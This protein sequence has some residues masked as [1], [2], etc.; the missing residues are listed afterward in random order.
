MIPSRL[1]KQ[2]VVPTIPLPVAAA[3]VPEP[4]FSPTLAFADFKCEYVW[5]RDH[6]IPPHSH[7]GP[8]FVYRVRASPGREISH[9][10]LPGQHNRGHIRTHRKSPTSLRPLRR[11]IGRRFRSLP[12]KATV[13][14][15]QVRRADMLRRDEQRKS[16]IAAVVAWNARFCPSAIEFARLS[17]DKIH[18]QQA[19]N[20]YYYAHLKVLD[21]TGP[22]HVFHARESRIREVRLE[23]RELINPVPTREAVQRARLE[24]SRL[25]NG[26]AARGAW[27][28]STREAGP[29][30][31]T[32]A[33]VVYD[34][35]QMWAS[36]PVA[37]DP[38]PAPLPPIEPV[39]EP[40]PAPASPVR[41]FS[42]LHAVWDDSSDDA[43][44]VDEEERL[45]IEEEEER[46]EVLDE[47]DDTES[48]M[49]ADSVSTTVSA[50]PVYD[51]AVPR[52]IP[53]PRRLGAPPVRQ[54]V[55]PVLP[56]YQAQLRVAARSPSPSPPYNAQTDRQTLIA[57]IFLD[58]DEVAPVAPIPIRAAAP[59]LLAEEPR[60]RPNAERE[61]RH[62]AQS[63][64]LSHT[65]RSLY[66]QQ[67]AVLSEIYASEG[68]DG[69]DA[70]LDMEEGEQIRAAI[71]LIDSVDAREQG[72]ERG[73]EQ[74]R[75]Q[76]GQG[77]LLGGIIRWFGY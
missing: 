69:F 37:V 67:R 5:E 61:R 8:A 22:R 1:A 72:Q 30:Q 13:D 34:A 24:Q 74:E 25:L 11:Q 12:H 76:A 10:R 45:V 7:L 39:D 66:E 2:E 43:T 18:E 41:Y 4:V 54:P 14:V 65:H 63:S 32:V 47:I 33:R 28:A 9:P 68:R 23:R 21:P 51:E 56:R 71:E 59:A 73:R 17:Y 6:V 42:A 77:G 46:L 19:A 62:Q 75:G 57:P 64:R 35:Q 55:E 26:P 50:P 49:S 38:A 70:A 40:V 29:A 52:R 58:D 27:R 15:G 31:G 16:R 3:P 44:E 48:V 20:E 53:Y 36:R 60:T